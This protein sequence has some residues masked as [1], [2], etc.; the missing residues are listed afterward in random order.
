MITNIRMQLFEALLN[1]VTAVSE[2]GR[3][4][5]AECFVVYWSILVSNITRFN[6]CNT[7]NV[8][9]G[10]FHFKNLP[11]PGLAWSVVPS[12]DSCGQPAVALCPGFWGSGSLLPLLTQHLDSC[13]A[14]KLREKFDIILSSS[15]TTLTITVI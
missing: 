9:C 4:K 1:I 8:L 7:K 15:S 14:V 11:L 13:G 3:G 2:S 10:N 12:S 6:I 5:I